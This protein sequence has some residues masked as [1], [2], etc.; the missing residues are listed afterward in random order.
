MKL[1]RCEPVKRQPRTFPSM[2]GIYVRKDQGTEKAPTRSRST[3]RVYGA[4]SR[5]TWPSIPEAREVTGATFFAPKETAGPR[6]RDHRADKFEDQWVGEVALRETRGRT[7]PR[8]P[9]MVQEAGH[10]R[11]CPDGSTALRRWRERSG[12]ITSPAASTRWLRERTSNWYD[13]YLEAA[14]QRSHERCSSPAIDRVAQGRT[15]LQSC[16]FGKKNKRRVTVTR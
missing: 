14:C 15:P 16:S 11:L 2:L 3:E 13:P 1:A 8:G 4:R 5:A 12:T 7:E 6:A 10:Q 9:I